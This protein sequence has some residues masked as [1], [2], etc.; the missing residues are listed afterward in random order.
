MRQRC[1]V[2]SFRTE[3]WWSD[4]VL[5]KLKAESYSHDKVLCMYHTECMALSPALQAK[6]VLTRG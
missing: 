3:R 5:H 2:V 1:R 4:K 6:T